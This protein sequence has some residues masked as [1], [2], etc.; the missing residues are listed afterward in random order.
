MR[1]RRPEF[2]GAPRILRGA[3]LGGSCLLLTEIGHSIAGGGHLDVGTGLAA[4]VALAL[5][6]AWAQHRRS[7]PGLVAFI[8]A[9]QLLLHVLMV[10][11]GSHG[12]HHA[13]L[14]PSPPMVLAHGLA[15]VA[16]A[17]LL[18]FGEST[19]QQWLAFLTA[20]AGPRPC[21]PGL[22]VVGPVIPAGS[23]PARGTSATLARRHLHRGPPNA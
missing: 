9:V 18:N 22:A 19:L 12:A 11:G 6:T 15:A 20:L 4:L 3:I 10:L 17:V 16:M 21:L 8:V 13:A 2:R 1:G 7:V 14:I 5:G 23:A